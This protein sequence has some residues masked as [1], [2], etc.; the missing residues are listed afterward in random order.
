MATNAGGGLAMRHGTMRAQ[1][2]GLEAV[3]SDGTIVRRLAGLLKDNAGYDL[4]VLLVGSEGTLGVVTAV[5]VRL[6]AARRH[7]VVALFGLADLDDALTLVTHL[8]ERCVSA[9][10]PGSSK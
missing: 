2:A 4:P 10:V 8:R 6:V 1:V 7:R 9:A 3:L 5:N